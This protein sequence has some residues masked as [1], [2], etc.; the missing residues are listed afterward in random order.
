[1]HTCIPSKALHNNKHDGKA[2]SNTT[3][4]T[5][6]Q[7]TESLAG[8]RS[9]KTLTKHQSAS[10]PFSAAEKRI[11]HTYA[12]IGKYNTQSHTH[13]HTSNEYI[14][15][16]T[17]IT[18][19]HDEDDDDDD[20]DDDDNDDEMDNDDDA[21]DEDVIHDDNKTGE[22]RVILL[23][24]LI[25]N[26]S[27][28]DF[29]AK[30]LLYIRQNKIVMHNLMKNKKSMN[31]EE[32]RQLYIRQNQMIIHNI[33]RKTLPLLRSDSTSQ[34]SQTGQGPSVMGLGPSDRDAS[35]CS[36]LPFMHV[37]ENLPA[38]S[39]QSAAAHHLAEAE[40]QKERHHTVHGI[41]YDNVHDNTHDIHTH[42]GTEK[43]RERERKRERKIVIVIDI[44]IV[45][46]ISY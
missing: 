37:H 5:E 29:E 31:F 19:H 3:V 7:A 33:T 17:A 41:V 14:S 39:S 2:I 43:E 45:I 24:R 18:R 10:T 8:L 42:I 32:Q 35:S 20:N 34:T 27:T 36:S 23:D 16:Q 22:V 21:N 13:T 11:N 15:T 38:Q 12:Y 46:V 25:Q 4:D 1:M 40:T 44:V 28:N 9:S 26:I 6:S 30:K